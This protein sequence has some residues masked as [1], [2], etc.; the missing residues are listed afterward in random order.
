M[1]SANTLWGGT[2]H[3]WC[4]YALLALGAPGPCPVVRSAALIC[5]MVMKMRAAAVHLLTDERRRGQFPRAS[6]FALQKRFM[7]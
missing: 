6:S 5:K 4:R 2:G 7:R 3:V 1:E